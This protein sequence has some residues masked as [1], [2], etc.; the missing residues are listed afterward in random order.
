M[1]GDL[2]TAIS[3]F[4]AVDLGAGS[5]RLV[6]GR[7]GADGW[8]LDEVGRFPTPTILDETSGHQC[9][10]LEV[11]VA[12]VCAS[13]DRAATEGPVA[14][15]GVDSWGVD[16][17]LLDAELRQVGKAVCYRDKRTNGQMEKFLSKISAQEVYRR[18]GI[19][20]LP[21]NTLYQLAAAC[22]QDRAWIDASRHLLMIPDYMH[23]RLAVFFRMNT[24]IQ[25]RRRPVAS[26]AIGTEPYSKPRDSRAT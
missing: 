21:I 19:Q 11:I 5:G 15:V 3:R 18:T 4:C 22:E 25:P 14:S 6:A 12:Q 16:Y 26:T 1:R 24:R 13:L 8:E 10:D 9:W 23:F 17:V 20:F 2:V 7:L